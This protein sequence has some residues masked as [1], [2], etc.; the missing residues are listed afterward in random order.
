VVRSVLFRRESSISTNGAEGS[1]GGD[2]ARVHFSGEFFGGNVF[3][4][5]GDVANEFWYV[6]DN[7]EV[8]ET[9][10][11]GIENSLS[12]YFDVVVFDIGNIHQEVS[13]L[14]GG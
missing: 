14:L 3:K 4:T 7:V 9:F 11:A 13:D 6:G 5:S 12:D 10:D 1:L 2:G 8:V